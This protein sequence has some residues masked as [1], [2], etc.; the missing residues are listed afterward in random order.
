MKIT[1][2]DF[3]RCKTLPS[4]IF[5]IEMIA[6]KIRLRMGREGPQLTF[7]KGKFLHPQFASDEM[8][9]Q[10]IPQLSSML[11]RPLPLTYSLMSIDLRP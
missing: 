2:M 11:E 1:L 8:M 10:P 4:A 7:G 5:F 9:N 6:C 3:S